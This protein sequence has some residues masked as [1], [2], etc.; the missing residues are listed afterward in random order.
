MGF[1]CGGFFSYWGVGRGV[2]RFVSFS[3]TKGTRT[4][5]MEGFFILGFRHRRINFY[6]RFF[7]CGVLNEG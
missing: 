1:F 2:M 7:G 5:F 6:D 4:V 3:I